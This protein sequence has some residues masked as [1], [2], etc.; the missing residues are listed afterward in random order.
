MKNLA[1]IPGEYL[2]QHDPGY[3]DRRRRPPEEQD[4]EKTLLPAM[5]SVR[6][7]IK[8]SCMQMRKRVL[9]QTRWDA[10]ATNPNQR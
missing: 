10:G 7:G 3:F 8:R 5:L 1:K 9:R 4:L 2:Y 6:A